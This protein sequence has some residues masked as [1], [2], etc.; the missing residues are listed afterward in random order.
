MKKLLSLLLVVI[1]MMSMSVS[2]FASALNSAEVT[3]T[4]TVPDAS[5]VLNVPASM[6]LYY[7]ASA[8][9]IDVSVERATNFNDGDM[10]MIAVS[11]TDLYSGNNTIPLSVLVTTYEDGEEVGYLQDPRE[12]QVSQLAYMHGYEGYYQEYY[13]FVSL[14]DWKAAAPGSYEAI[15][16]FDSQYWPAV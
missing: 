11:S 5:Y 13:A 14:D 9:K 1:L 4:A 7:G 16:T 15:V 2:V 3:L 12:E 8:Q 6:E 10:V